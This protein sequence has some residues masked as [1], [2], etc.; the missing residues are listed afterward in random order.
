MTALD[1]ALFVYVAGA[2]VG[3]WVA[4]LLLFGPG[5]DG[6]VWLLLPWIVLAVVF[7]PITLLYCWGSL[8]FGPGRQQ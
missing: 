4:L 1:I 5:G 3:V 7:W 8:Y 6:S 2:S